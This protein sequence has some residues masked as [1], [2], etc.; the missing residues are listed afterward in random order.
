MSLSLR[1][2][3]SFIYLYKKDEYKA[4]FKVGV[5]KQLIL[6]LNIDLGK[7]SLLKLENRA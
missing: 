7:Q 5:Q 3:N 4:R 1:T 6:E 2:T